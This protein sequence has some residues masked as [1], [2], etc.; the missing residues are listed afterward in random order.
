MS[1]ITGRGAP[2]TRRSVREGAAPASAPDAKQRRRAA[3]RTLMALLDGGNVAASDAP[4]L[5][6]WAILAPRRGVTI[7]I[8]SADLSVIAA[9][10][11]DGL[12]EWRGRG[13]A[14]RAVATASGLA[15]ARRIAAGT[16]DEAF[17]VQH[18]TL[19]EETRDAGE[20]PLRVNDGESPL[21]WLARRKDRDGA[22]LL[23]SARFEAGE[24]LRRDLTVAQMLPRV[25]SNWC[26]VPSGVEPGQ[27]AQHMSDVV[28]AARQRVGRALDAAGDD[29]AGLLLDV[30]GFLK[31]LE[32]IERERGWPPRSA[33]IVL[34]FALGRLADHY[35]L[36]TEARG[37]SR[38]RGLRGWAA[39]DARP[40]AG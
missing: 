27:G 29:L 38:A 33:R 8:G 32:H 6:R 17:R 21:A 39:A 20:T 35:G 30:C 12:V 24:R 4:G 36:A 18:M 5:P 25:T 19:R 2:R 37:P 16:G 13:A 26:A 7:R 3:D 23:D 9:L 34:G 14:R 1:E 11:R 10:E 22:P 15:R 31:G 40:G 28:V